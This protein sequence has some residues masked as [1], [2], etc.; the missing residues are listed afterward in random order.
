[1]CT[2]PAE[3]GSYDSPRWHIIAGRLHLILVGQTYFQ[4]HI[5]E[6]SYLIPTDPMCI[7]GRFGVSELKYHSVCLRWD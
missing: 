4:P 1:M 3:N 6:L 7:Y 5:G 2:S